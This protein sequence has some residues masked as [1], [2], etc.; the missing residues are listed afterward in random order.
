MLVKCS[1]QYLVERKYLLGGSYCC[2]YE[3][4]LFYFIFLI[5]MAINE[6]PERE[7]TMKAGGEALWICKEGRI[8]LGPRGRM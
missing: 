1:A 6:W 2:Y 3:L 8:K 5:L 7:G 4:L